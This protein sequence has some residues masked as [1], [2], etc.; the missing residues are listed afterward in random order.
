VDVTR[1]VTLVLLQTPHHP[2]AAP[3]LW[4]FDD[5]DDDNDERESGRLRGHSSLIG[6][7]PATFAH[8]KVDDSDTAARKRIK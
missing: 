5:D 8:L 3:S 1:D 6:Q 7:T 4:S 2:N